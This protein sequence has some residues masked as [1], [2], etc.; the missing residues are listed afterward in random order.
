MPS[1]MAPGPAAQTTLVRRDRSPWAAQVPQFQ[2]SK[3]VHVPSSIPKWLIP[4][5]DGPRVGVKV[6]FFILD[7]DGPED[8]RLLILKMNLALICIIA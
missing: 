4:I 1:A 3:A 2:T 5:R 7:T 8:C 6:T